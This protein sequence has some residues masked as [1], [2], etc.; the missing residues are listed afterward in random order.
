MY[1]M[2]PHWLSQTYHC[3]V[4]QF[5]SL[6]AAN[7]WHIHNM[8]RSNVKVNELNASSS[9]VC[10][11]C[12]ACCPEYSRSSGIAH[13]SY[14]P[15]KACSLYKP[16]LHCFQMCDFHSC[17]CDLLSLDCPASVAWQSACCNHTVHVELILRKMQLCTC[18]STGAMLMPG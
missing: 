1:D 14:C 18:S 17:I 2:Q 11:V 15:T 9:H 13:R 6:P 7:R 10:F 16:A 4:Q 3:C 8:T 5:R 12:I